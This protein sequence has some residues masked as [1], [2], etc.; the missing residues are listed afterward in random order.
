MSTLTFLLSRRLYATLQ[1]EGVVVKV[2]TDNSTRVT[3]FLTPN[4][5]VS[6]L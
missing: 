6:D 1:E 3:V 2:R 5:V 4:F